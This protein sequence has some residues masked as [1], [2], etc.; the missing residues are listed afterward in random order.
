MPTDQGPILDPQRDPRMRYS[1][2]WFIQAH[3]GRR[4]S[5]REST[6]QLWNRCLKT[7]EPRPTR[8]L[9]LGQ[10]EGRSGLWLLQNLQPQLFVGI[11]PWVPD[12]RWHR[13]QFDAWKANYFHNLQ[14]FV[15]DEFHEDEPLKFSMRSRT[16]NVHQICKSS[17]D[18]LRWEIDT[19]FPGQPFDMVYVDAA[20]D[21]IGA[22]TDMVLAWRKLAPGG[23]MLI[24]DMD[25]RWH[26]ARPAVLEAARAFWTIVEWCAW[27]IPLTD[28]TTGHANKR[29]MWIRKR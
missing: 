26:N 21:A 10:C 12:R 13:E 7:L 1:V 16:T 24:D 4:K 27:Q 6:E 25:R 18:Y 17:Q 29:Q 2:N 15:G 28:A 19:D 8:I 22:M 20:H 14:T 9:E 5:P 3:E 23:I 11:D